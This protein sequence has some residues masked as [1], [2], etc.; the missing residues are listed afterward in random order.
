MK[1]MKHLTSLLLVLVA[2]MTFSAFPQSPL[3]EKLDLVYQ[4]GQEDNRFGAFSILNDID[5]E[6]GSTSDKN[7]KLQYNYYRGSLFYRIDKFNEAIPLLHEYISLCDELH[8]HHQPQYLDA[9][10]TLAHCYKAEGEYNKA[11]RFYRRTLTANKEELEQFPEIAYETLFG[12]ASVSLAHNDTTMIDEYCSLATEYSVK[13]YISEHGEDENI[14]VYRKACQELADVEKIQGKGSKPFVQALLKKADALKSLESTYAYL[15]NYAQAI[16]IGKKSIGLN[17]E[18]FYPYYDELLHVMA[19]TDSINHINSLLPVAFDYWQSINDTT[20]TIYGKY[21]DISMGLNGLGYHQH[22]LVY[23]LKCEEYLNNHQ[24]LY[25]WKSACFLNYLNLMEAY[26]CLHEADKMVYYRNQLIALS[27]VSS[28]DETICSYLIKLSR[29]AFGSC[30]FDLAK[31]FC[32]ITLKYLEKY[33]GCN[34]FNYIVTLN[35][36]GISLMYMNMLDDALK[37]FNE[38]LQLCDTEE[39]KDAIYPALYNN[40]GKAYMLKGEYHTALNYLDKAVE[41][42]IKI[43]GVIGERTQSYIDKCKSKL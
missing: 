11:A 23:S 41:W 17:N 31:E 10:R 22:S 6:C 16:S 8:L 2:G 43:D 15:Y 29:D 7:I 14:I 33:L 35:D 18:V 20:R 40:I 36:R 3:Q 24:D 5:E 34:N 12:L 19:Q 42:Q 38:A 9:L 25:N 21:I 30:K 37:D 4:Y 26:A 27:E 39:L 28:I 13:E 32:T 1:V